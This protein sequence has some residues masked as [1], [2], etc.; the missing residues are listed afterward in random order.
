MAIA[1]KIG[2]SNESKKAT[3]ITYSVFYTQFF[4]T[5]ILCLIAPWCVREFTTG[6]INSFFGGIYTD[7]NAFWFADVGYVIVFNMCFNASWPIME[8]F[9]FYALRHVKRMRDQKKF[10]PNA[11][12]KTTTETLFGFTELYSGPKFAVHYKY[13]YIMMVVFVT[14]MYGAILPILFPIALLQIF[15]LY[16]CERL[17]IFYSYQRPPMYDDTLTKSIIRTM[18]VA[19]AL[20]ML[21]GAWGFSNQQIYR[22][23]VN[24]LDPEDIY[25]LTGHKMGQFVT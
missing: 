15:V 10:W 22:N 3:F 5:G 16:V 17:M 25:P 8:F 2:F 18:Y 1:N 14:F 4:Q 23:T 21:V 7:M 19:P 9:L 24:W 20:M 12:E 6:F 13:S 11:I